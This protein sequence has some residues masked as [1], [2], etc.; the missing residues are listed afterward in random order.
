MFNNVTIIGVGLI[1]GSLALAMKEKGFAKNIIGVGRSKTSLDK[2]IELA[3]TKLHIINLFFI[4][5]LT[6]SLF[7]KNK[8]TIII[9]IN[10]VSILSI[11]MLK[12]DISDGISIKITKAINIILSILLAILDSIL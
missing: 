9:D 3:N 12:I 4:A 2:A 5:S 1:G 11:L 10:I 7:I 6:L 8:Y